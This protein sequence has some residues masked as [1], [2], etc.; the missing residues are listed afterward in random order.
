M[1]AFSIQEFVLVVV[2]AYIIFLVLYGFFLI[3]EIIFPAEK[4]QRYIGKLRNLGITAIYLVLGV[5]AIDALGVIIPFDLHGA[6][7]LTLLPSIVVVLVYVFTFDC[8]YYWYHRALHTFP[9]L[10]PIHEIHHA[11]TELN[12]TTSYRTYWMELPLQS[13]IIGLPVSF[14]VGDIG[15]AYIITYITLIVWEFFTHANV[16]LHLYAFSPV[17]C[18]PQV[19]R[20][21]H[22]ILQEHRDKNFAQYFPFI[23]KLFGTYY[24]PSHNEFPPTGSR[25]LSVDASMGTVLKH[26][27]SVWRRLFRSRK[28]AGNIDNIAP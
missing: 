23:D 27:L 1:H 12:V 25:G 7:R 15:T 16:R 11:D 18:G 28:V 3:F 9:A 5:F 2:S 24:A 6:A 13:V 20:I 8:T 19:H 10:W 26:P 22:S 21:H 4:G 17:I 14:A